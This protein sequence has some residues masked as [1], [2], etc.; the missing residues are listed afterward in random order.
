MVR[1]YGGRMLAAARRLLGNEQD[2]ND[3]VQQAF[4]SVFKS[5]AGFN[6]EAKL[7][8]WLHR[9][10]VNAALAQ[11]RYR[12]RRPELSID[13]LLPDSTKRVD[14]PATLHCGVKS[15]RP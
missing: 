7:S 14:G 6:G 2:A 1:Q 5:I 12:R 10:V 8:T 9:I 11:M 15:A 4:I 13:D 3:A